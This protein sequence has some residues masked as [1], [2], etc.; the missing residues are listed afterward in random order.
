M[1]TP[2][3]DNPFKGLAYLYDGL[4]TRIIVLTFVTFFTDIGHPALDLQSRNI[5]N[6]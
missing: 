1:E 6:C 5:E 2:E 4:L 3:T